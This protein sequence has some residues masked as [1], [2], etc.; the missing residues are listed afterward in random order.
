M[1]GLDKFIRECEYVENKDDV[2]AILQNVDI[3]LTYNGVK[4]KDGHNMRAYTLELNGVAF[5]YYEGM[6]LEPMTDKNKPEKAVNAIWCVLTDVEA[7]AYCDT[8]DEFMREYGYTDEIQARR[9]YKDIGS[10]SNKLA[11]VFTDDEVATL[12]ENVR[13]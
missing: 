4:L 8:V 10:N 11:R 13:F 1:T 12:T 2:L 3:E 9:I 7:L 5:S 6:G